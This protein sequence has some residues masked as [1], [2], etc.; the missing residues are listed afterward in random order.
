MWDMVEVGGV[1]WE[2]TSLTVD[3]GYGRSGWV[4]RVMDEVYVTWI[5]RYTLVPLFNS[6]SLLYSKIPQA[7]FY[8]KI[9]R[10]QSVS[11]SAV[12]DEV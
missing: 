8:Q 11:Q 5:D 1:S 3:V 10:S 7:C 2:V 9:V 12:C 4:L 6:V